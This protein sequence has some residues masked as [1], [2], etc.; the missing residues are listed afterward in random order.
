[1]PRPIRIDGSLEDPAWTDLPWSDEF[2]DITGDPARRPRYRTRV[3]MGWD[4]TY[5]YVGAELEEP[6]V[7][8]TIRERN[9][10]I[11]EGLPCLP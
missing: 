2:V 9:A 8:G 11:F 6:H 10:V 1:V 4:D 7:W 3:K 5:F